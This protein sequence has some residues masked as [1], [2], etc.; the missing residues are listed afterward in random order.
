MEKENVVKRGFENYLD[1]IEKIVLAKLVL[2]EASIK[3]LSDKMGVSE[4]TCFRKLKKYNLFIE[5]NRYTNRINSATR[6]A[7]AGR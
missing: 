1:D 6:L 5:N 2:D 7:E 3:T 4:A